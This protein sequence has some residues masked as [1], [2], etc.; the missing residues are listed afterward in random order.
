MSIDIAFMYVAGLG[1]NGASCEYVDMI[2]AKMLQTAAGIDALGA[3]ATP[4]QQL[5]S[6]TIKRMG[7]QPTGK[8]TADYRL[9]ALT[10]S[11]G[12]SYRF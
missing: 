12:I 5:V 11:I 10:P 1:K 8:F 9:H 7:F 2:G 3:N 4:A 6:A